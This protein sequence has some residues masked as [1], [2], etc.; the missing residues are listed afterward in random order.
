MDNARLVRERIKMQFDMHNI[1]DTTE[2]G[3]YGVLGIP[4]K[5]AKNIIYGVRLLWMKLQQKGRD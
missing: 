5:W 2:C 4:V 1:G 3:Y